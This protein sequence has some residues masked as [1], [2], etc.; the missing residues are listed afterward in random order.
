MGMGID[1]ALAAFILPSPENGQQK[2]PLRGGAPHQAPPKGGGLSPPHA[3]QPPVGFCCAGSRC[4]QRE[5]ELSGI[6]SLSQVRYLRFS[7]IGGVPRPLSEE[8]SDSVPSAR[9]EAVKLNS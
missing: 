6:L 1:A 9:S 8:P 5:R 7:F 3:S 2:A 4:R